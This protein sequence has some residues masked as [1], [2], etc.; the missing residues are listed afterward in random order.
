MAT[1]NR[2]YIGKGKS[3][4][5]MQIAKCTIRVADLMEHARKFEGVDYVTFE[6]AKMKEPDQFGRDY[7]VYIVTKED[8]EPAPVAEKK[9]RKSKKEKEPAF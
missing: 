2:I 5:G 7:T 4:K 1:Y 9:T 8:D 6:V 3:V